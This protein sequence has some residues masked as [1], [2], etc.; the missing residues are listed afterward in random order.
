[1]KMAARPPSSEITTPMSG[2][3]KAMSRVTVNQTRV[4]MIRR[5]RSVISTSL[6]SAT[7]GV[8]TNRLSMATLSTNNVVKLYMK[9]AVIKTC[10][11]VLGKMCAV[12]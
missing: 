5:R 7:G 6:R 2:I 1:M 8:L 11:A 3:N 9:C 12:S 4:V 10:C